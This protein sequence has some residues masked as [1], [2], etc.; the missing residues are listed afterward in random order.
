MR[1]TEQ[2]GWLNKQPKKTMKQR[3]QQNWLVAYLPSEKY[4]F[5]SWDYEIPNI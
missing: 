5:V 1:F 4:Q 2:R 3:N